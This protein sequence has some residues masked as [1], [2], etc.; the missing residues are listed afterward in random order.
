M[1]SDSRY[2][3]A[4]VWVWLPEETMPVV[5]GVLTRAGDRLVFNYGR[6]YLARANAIPIYEPELPLKAGALPLLAGLSMPN[7]I[8]DAA[9]D[10]W[11]RRVI[12]NHRLGRRGRQ[13]DTAE[14]DELT[15]LLESGSDRSGALD[16]QL[17]PTGYVPR[18][19]AAASLDDL[20]QAV[21]KV[22]QGAPLDP[23]LDQALLHG[24]SLGGARPKALIA[25][26]ERKYIAKF[27][28]RNDVYSVV[29]A[30]FIAMRLAALVGIAAA[31]VRLV[32]ALDKDVS[33]RTLRSHKN[34]RRLAPN[35]HGFG[36]HAVRP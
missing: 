10:A 8:R 32:R 30:E 13:V 31:P 15:Y 33:D 11:G 2:Q 19:S 16:F 20:L 14:L 23:D 26:D 24:S 22:E 34:R 7:C 3:E 35:G 4:Y 1:T 17:S 6:S 12:I 28:S 18:L 25:T 9:P 5:A 29:K 27:S 21:D 36:A